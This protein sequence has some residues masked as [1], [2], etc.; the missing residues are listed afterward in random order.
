[1][2]T[3]IFADDIAVYVVLMGVMVCVNRKT[4]GD[5]RSEK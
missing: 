2:G 4:I 3:L 1:M 5:A